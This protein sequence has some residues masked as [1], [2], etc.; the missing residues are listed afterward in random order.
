MDRI[1]VEYK[2]FAIRYDEGRDEW[3]VCPDPDKSGSVSAHKSLS[4]AR[5]AVDG[6]VRE[7][8]ERVPVLVRERWNYS[9]NATKLEAAEVTSHVEGAQEAW[10]ITKEG[11]RRI[12]KFH[13]LILDC[14]Y[15]RAVYAELRTTEAGAIASRKEWDDKVKAINGR[16]N[17]YDPEKSKPTGD[18]ADGNGTGA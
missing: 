16:F 4:L 12:V 10:I 9:E 2:G 8:F 1:E 15:N 17:R 5:K 18:Q 6:Y 7:A 3:N 11:K 14:G 13:D